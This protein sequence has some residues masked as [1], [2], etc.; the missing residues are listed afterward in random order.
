MIG[1]E[2]YV[3]FLDALKHLISELILLEKTWK[4][5]KTVF[6][7]IVSYYIYLRTPEFGDGDHGI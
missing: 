4:E 3:W 6:L 7:K 1:G 5:I 2:E